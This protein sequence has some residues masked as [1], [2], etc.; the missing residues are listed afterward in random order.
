MKFDLIIANPPYGAIG[1]KIT[2]LIVNKVDFDEYVNLLPVNDIIKDNELYKHIQLIESIE[3]GAFKDAAV[4]P[5]LS[6]IV[7][8][9]VFFKDKL[10][11]V[12]LSKRAGLMEK[13]LLANVKRGVPYTNYHQYS[14]KIIDGEIDHNC[15]LCLGRR[16]FANGH[17][18]YAKNRDYDFNYNKIDL[19]NLLSKITHSYKYAGK[20][21]IIWGSDIY[22][23]NS[24]VERDNFRDFMYS[25]NG[26]R[27]YGLLFSKV[28]VDSTDARLYIF[29][30]V[31]WTRPQTVE[32]ILKDYNYTPDEIKEVMEDLKNYKY[33]KDE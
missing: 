30:K 32:S 8:D 7:K 20:E 10:E 29:P 5:A 26:Y 25:T 33:L 21:Q 1:A 13:Y 31:D 4:T 27:F 2:S 6:I 12:I 23:F 15:L 19:K 11:L 17:L 3:R 28:K 22:Q 24:K 9:Q 16:D 14:Q 18:P